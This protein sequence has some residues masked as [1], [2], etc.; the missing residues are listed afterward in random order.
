MDLGSACEVA[1]NPIPVGIGAQQ[2]LQWLQLDTE[3]QDPERIQLM[4][5]AQG[6]AAAWWHFFTTW[7]GAGPLLLLLVV[8]CIGCTA[9]AL[10]VPPQIP[11]LAPELFYNEVQNEIRNIPV[12]KPSP[13][14][15]HY[16]QY[17]LQQYQ[18]HVRQYRELEK[19]WEEEGPPNF[20]WTAFMQGVG[21]GA[22]VFSATLA[23]CEYR[24]STITAWMEMVE[25]W[26]ATCSWRTGSKQIDPLADEDS[27]VKKIFNEHELSEA[28]VAGKGG[29]TNQADKKA[30]AKSRA[31]APQKRTQHLA[32]TLQPRP[33]Q[34]VRAQQAAA[35]QKA[36][37]KASEA[38]QE[39]KEEED[40][41]DED[42]GSSTRDEQQW[43]Q[44]QQKPARGSVRQMLDHPAA[45][46][47]QGRLPRIQVPVV[48]QQA[49]KPLLA[50]VVPAK[51]AAAKAAEKEEPEPQQ[52]GAAPLQPQPT[53][54]KAAGGSSPPVEQA[55]VPPTS[56]ADPA[57]AA[58]ALMIRPPGLK[59]T[60]S[61][62]R[63]EAAAR[64]LAHAKAH[65]RAA[66][67]MV[68]AKAAANKLGSL[69]K[70]EQ[71]HRDPMK[72]EVKSSGLSG[73]QAE[74]AAAV[75]EEEQQ[76]NDLIDALA[77]EPESEAR[78]AMHSLLEQQRLK[79]LIRVL[80]D[81]EVQE[82]LLQQG[83][84]MRTLLQRW[85]GA[86]RYETVEAALSRIASTPEENADEVL[87][88]VESVGLAPT[89]EA[90][91]GI[92]AT[93]KPGKSAA[94]PGWDP[95]GLIS[96]QLLRAEA[97]E[98]IPAA[99]QAVAVPLE[100]ALAEGMAVPPGHV[101]VLAAAPGPGEAG[102][103]GFVPLMPSAFAEY[104]MQDAFLCWRGD[105]GFAIESGAAF[106]ESGQ[107]DPFS[108]NTAA[109]SGEGEGGVWKNPR[110]GRESGKRSRRS[111][112][113]PGAG[114]SRSLG[115]AWPPLP[116]ASANSKDRPAPSHIYAGPIEEVVWPVGRVRSRRAAVQAALGVD[117]VR[118]EGV[119]ST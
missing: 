27:V 9:Y 81:E 113:K 54:A 66:R 29:K 38:Q 13:Y 119:G 88:D 42:S 115:R 102:E 76:Q 90:A 85:L 7:G 107:F 65:A 82:Q 57:P 56:A 19:K 20:N 118:E 55:A 1:E 62:L 17:Y 101:L 77:S 30:H 86:C 35:K 24:Y 67:Q 4:T 33:V 26:W 96:N 40:E 97:P 44:V 94:K 37:V 18:Q 91:P 36:Q 59:P 10:H 116:A 74:D 110:A 60:Q 68:Q 6:G 80:A 104:P 93:S 58:K 108:G 53:A 22:W 3:G 61:Q 84:A 64:A 25:D 69:L 89:V 73:V 79:D 75:L 112:A 105:E 21:L 23:F 117:A 51:A 49:P 111:G 47:V 15:S 72:V 50:T 95:A 32:D 106:D 70:Q 48:Q 28:G 109:W 34:A 63:E 5:C 114:R 98:F 78:A 52:Q 83:V 87:T 99:V 92:W 45:V 12:P 8:W 43:V 14:Y 100:V 2:F 31:Q 11:M 39:G 16:R 41:E 103:E 71:L 46:P